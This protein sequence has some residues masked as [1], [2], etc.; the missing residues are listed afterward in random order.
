M[1]NLNTPDTMSFRY[2]LLLLKLAFFAFWK[3]LSLLQ[4]FWWWIWL[5]FRLYL[6]RNR[7]NRRV[8]ANYSMNLSS[9]TM[10]WFCLYIWCL[11]FF[12]GFDFSMRNSSF[13][14]IWP[15][16]SF[17]IRLVILFFL[18]FLKLLIVFLLLFLLL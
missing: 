3:R 9:R 10:P 14:Y 16:I 15:H 6:I 5:W 4:L 12:W 8:F 2:F 7:L 1:L 13:G 18:N 17:L 11:N